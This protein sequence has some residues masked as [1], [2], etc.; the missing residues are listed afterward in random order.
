MSNALEKAAERLD[1]LGTQ[2][3]AR[4]FAEMLFNLRSQQV[5]L[6][7]EV[8]ANRYDPDEAYKQIKEDGEAVYVHDPQ[9]DAR[10]ED[11]RACKSYGQRIADLQAGQD[12]LWEDAK[13]REL[14]PLI[15]EELPKVRERVQKRQDQDTP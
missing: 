15:E 8:V 3:T 12:E 6:E 14:S 4:M 11:G 7:L 9:G 1:P 2:Q 10:D 5:G 13:V